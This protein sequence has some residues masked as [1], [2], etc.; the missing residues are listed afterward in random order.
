MS[1]DLRVAVVTESFYPHVDGSTTTVRAVVDRL[2]DR[3]HRVLLV[4]PAPG[5]S[6]Y[7]G[8]R[9]VR[10][11]VGERPGRQVRA[12]LAEFRPDL[13]HLTSPGTL[14]RKGLKHARALGVPTVVVQQA[15]LDERAGSRWREKVLP[16]ADVVVATARWMVDRLALLGA[17]PVLWHPGVD[18]AAFTPRLHD[19]WLHDRWAGR[20]ATGAEQRVVVGFVGS[21]HRRHDVRRLVDLAEV[22]GA[23]LVV[24]GE[25]PQRRWLQA[26]LPAA[27]FTGE[28]HGGHLASAIASLDALVH[29]ATDLTCAHALR[30][31]AA[32]G[33]PVVAAR[34]GGATDVVRDLETGLLFD[35]GTRHGFRDAVDAVVADRHRGLLGTHGRDLA[36]RRSWPEAADELVAGPYASA[37]ARGSRASLVTSASAREFPTGRYEGYVTRPSG[38]LGAAGR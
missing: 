35:P 16:R 34:S 13:V 25:G 2:L 14:G 30:E 7:R 4:A 32:S 36:L 21:L 17:A 10:V 28:L 29:P 23:R 9:V 1:P 38:D 20:D 33:V 5:L 11:Q 18:T 15:P 31:A 27:R 37:L 19:R 8:A 22:P 6:S 3:G 12:A 24:V 26:R